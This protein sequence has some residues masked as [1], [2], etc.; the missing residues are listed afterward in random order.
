MPKVARKKRNSAQNAGPY[1]Q[2]VAKMN[3]ANSI[4]RMNTDI[5]Q[6]VLK[7]PLVAQAYVLFRL[8]LWSLPFSLRLTLK[9]GIGSLTKLISSKATY[10]LV[11]SATLIPVP[12]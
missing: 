11:S 4:F 6:H 10:V 2:A 9:I 1:S 5:G 12:D 8:S 7:N 3:A